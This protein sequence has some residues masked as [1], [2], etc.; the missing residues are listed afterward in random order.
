MKKV[1]QMRVDA[2]YV[3][4][5]NNEKLM[6]HSLFVSWWEYGNATLIISEVEK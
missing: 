2:V 5:R 6:T 3:N 4:K 1:K